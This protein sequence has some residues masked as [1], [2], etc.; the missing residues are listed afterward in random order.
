L[1]FIK[2]NVELPID[3]NF[4]VGF[5]IVCEPRVVL[6]LRIHVFSEK[7]ILFIVFPGSVALGLAIPVIQ[8]Y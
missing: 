5:F 3:E 8:E 7:F 4:V 6:R 1:V 2:R